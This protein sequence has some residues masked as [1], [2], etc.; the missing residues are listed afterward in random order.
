MGRIVVAA[1]LVVAF[2]APA[3]ADFQAGYAALGRSD[4][5]TALREW[6]PLAGRG[7][8]NSQYNL[9]QM[10]YKGLGVPQDYAEAATWFR[11]AA[12]QGFVDAQLNLG[13]MYHNGQGV[14]RDNVQAHLWFNLAAAQGNAQA[15]QNRD[16]VARKMTTAQIVE[17]QKLARQW[18]PKTR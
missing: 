12:D 1:A 9:G 14:P 18:R 2:M 10:Y 16:I 15:R 7:H 4:Y 8:A 11:R 5:A 6:R 13:A 3:R 17:A